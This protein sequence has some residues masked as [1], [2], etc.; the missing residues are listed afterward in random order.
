MMMEQAM[1]STLTTHLALS[2]VSQG[3]YSI[4]KETVAGFEAA[5]GKMIQLVSLASQL[6]AIDS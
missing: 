2:A 6:L 3:L 1:G 4:I 5:Y